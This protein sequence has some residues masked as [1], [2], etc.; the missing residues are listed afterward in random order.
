MLLTPA[1]FR[2]MET[3]YDE[4]IDYWDDSPFRMLSTAP[5]ITEV[6]STEPANAG[7]RI[8]FNTSSSEEYYYVSNGT[9]WMNIT[10]I[11]QEAP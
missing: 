2:Q 9:S 4:A 1:R 7:G 11:M 8:Y 6:S 5:I 10:D 3:Q